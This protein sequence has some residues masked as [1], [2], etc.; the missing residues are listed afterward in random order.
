MKP[1]MTK[2]DIA[3]GVE[4]AREAL[5]HGHNTRKIILVVS[6]D[7]RTNWDPGNEKEWTA[8]LGHADTSGER[9]GAIPVFRMQI[10]F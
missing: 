2:G 9:A 10:L 6:D 8:A 4:A 7:Q 5:T 1:G 3:A